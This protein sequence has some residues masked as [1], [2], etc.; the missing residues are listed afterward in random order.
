[1][2]K[3]DTSAQ[4][5]LVGKGLSILTNDA[6]VSTGQVVMRARVVGSVLMLPG[7][8]ALLSNRRAMMETT[9]FLIR[10]EPGEAGDLAITQAR[11]S[12]PWIEIEVQELTEQYPSERGTPAGWPGD[13]LLRA[14]LK[15]GA[16][17]G[18][19]TETVRFKT[20][21]PREP[22]VKLQIA[23][24]IQPAV[25]LNA[26]EI[27]LVPGQPL[28]VLASMR[29][30]LTQTEVKLSATDRR[31]TARTEPGRG[32]FFK[33]H[34]EWNGPAPTDPVELKMQ[35]GGETQTASVVVEAE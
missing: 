8:K 35:V 11:A 14:T 31:L 27:R 34:L 10:Q 20:G 21:L 9:H 30:G 17:S 23:V 2:A 5:G 24:D 7:Y 4:A 12:V 1:M 3:L 22:E 28:M 6:A 32:R 13:W 33:I 29:P 18:N 26:E 16:P 19:H 15:D 25:N